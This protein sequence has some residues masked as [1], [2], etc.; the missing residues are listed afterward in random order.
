MILE[1]IK[2]IIV[3]VTDIE[4]EEITLKTNIKDD[5]DIDSLDLFQIVNEIEEEFDIK[6]EDVE[7][8]A[9]VEDVIKFVES[10]K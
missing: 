9:T 1:K 6:I 7:A 3:E 10:N 8:I 5:L 4:P 2:E